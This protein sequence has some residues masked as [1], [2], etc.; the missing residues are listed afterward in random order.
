MCL[1]KLSNRHLHDQCCHAGTLLSIKLIFH[2]LM[3][4]AARGTFRILCIAKRSVFVAWEHLHLRTFDKINQRLN[5]WLNKKLFTY[6][7]TGYTSLSKGGGCTYRKILK[8]QV[9]NKNNFTTSKVENI[10]GYQEISGVGFRV[11]KSEY[12]VSFGLAP[13][14]W[15]LSPSDPQIQEPFN[16]PFRVRDPEQ[17]SDS[18]FPQN[19]CRLGQNLG[20][21]GIYT[22]R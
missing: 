19:V 1:V 22:Q 9:K 8:W 13:R 5:N 11:R 6:C 18:K 12:E 21:R 10:R 14:N 3:K 17:T 7:N 4:H 15:E 2:L 20:S 16:S